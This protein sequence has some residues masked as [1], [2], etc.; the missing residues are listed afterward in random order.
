MTFF[1][2]HILVDFSD[3]IF[4]FLHFFYIVLCEFYSICFFLSFFPFFLIILFFA[5]QLVSYPMRVIIFI[6]LIVFFF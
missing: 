2:N 6:S 4:Y 5:F 1:G 3:Y